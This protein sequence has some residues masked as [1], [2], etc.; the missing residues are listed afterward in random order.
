MATLSRA[1]TAALLVA[2]CAAAPGCISS[3]RRLDAKA[4][5][6]RAALAFVAEWP[7]SEAP[8]DVPATVRQAALGSM[9]ARHFQASAIHSSAYLETFTQQKL[10]RSRVEALR[11]LAPDA[12]TRVLVETSPRWF[13]QLN[14]Q[15]KWTVAVRVSIDGPTDAVGAGG[16]TPAKAPLT[17]DDSVTVFT[18]YAYEGPREAL[19]RAAPVIARVLEGAIDEYLASAN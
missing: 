14:G 2:A 11:K 6:D 17:V 4:G 19:D 9:K 1:A 12:H 5:Q 8:S 16:E 18:R 15:V 13:S 7:G 3:Q 10:S